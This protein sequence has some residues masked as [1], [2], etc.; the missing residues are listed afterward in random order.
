MSYYF[1]RRLFGV[2]LCRQSQRSCQDRNGL[3]NFSIFRQSTTQ[4][5]PIDG[6]KNKKCGLYAGKVLR[7]G[8]KLSLW[9]KR[10]KRL[11][12]WCMTLYIALL[13][14]WTTPN[15][16]TLPCSRWLVYQ[17]VIKASWLLKSSSTK[18]WHQH[19]WRWSRFF[20]KFSLINLEP[21]KRLH[22]QVRSS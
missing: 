8:N 19:Y 3:G 5:I 6:L 17:K 10:L 20:W 21:T 22:F 15:L 4:R 7:K 1:R 11:M 2:I 12:L 9:H 16:T 18:H 14:W 13:L